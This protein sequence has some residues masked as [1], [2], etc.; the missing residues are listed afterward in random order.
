MDNSRFSTQKFEATPIVGILRG[1]DLEAT[2]NIAEAFSKAGLTTLEITMNSPNIETVLPE[3]VRLFPELN[4]GAGTVCS[5]EELDKAIDLGS[6]FIVTPIIDVDVI[7][8]CVKKEIPIFPGAYTP[9]EIYTAWSLGATAVKVFP[10]TQLGTTYIKDVLAPLNTIKLL[11]TGGVSLD[12][13]SSFFAAGAYGVGMG[14]SLI[15]KKMVA[16]KDYQ[17]LESHF[18]SIKKAASV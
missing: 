18:K 2:L 8:N 3:V 14:S 9:T 10:A 4:I 11:P 5:Q 15:D 6:Q 16:S 12:N 13:I 7:K 17:S 1:L